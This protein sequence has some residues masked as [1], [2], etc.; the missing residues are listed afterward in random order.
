MMWKYLFRFENS[1]FFPSRV[2]HKD[3]VLCNKSVL[4]IIESASCLSFWADFLRHCMELGSAS[5][6]KVIH[7]EIFQFFCQIVFFL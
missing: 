3:Q 6:E 2:I 1:V 7:C 5:V 4:L